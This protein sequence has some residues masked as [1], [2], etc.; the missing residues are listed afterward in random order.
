MSYP[1]IAGKS[2]VVTGASR[3]L[4]LAI[5][6]AFVGAGGWVTLV[7][8]DQVVERVAHSIGAYG[9][10]ADISDDAAIT[11]ALHQIPRIDILINNAG[12]ERLTPLDDS[13]APR[14]RRRS[15]ASSKSTS[16]APS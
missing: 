6:T 10:V 14:T 1:G 12:L 11:A 9:A 3:G 16:P 7:A 4:G 2:V 13:S 15:G 5:A 8:E